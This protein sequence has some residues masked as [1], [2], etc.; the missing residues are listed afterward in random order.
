MGTHTPR[1]APVI[2][3]LLLVYGGAS[4]VHFTH[5]AEYLADYPN[6]PTWL[7]PSVIYGAWIATTALGICG[8]LLLRWGY[9]ALGFCV[10]A[11]YAAIGFDSLTHYMVAPFEHHTVT[12]HVTIWL[13]VGAAGTLLA[14]L[15][16]VM[17]KLMWSKTSGRAY[18]A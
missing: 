15:A 7:S 3:A 6:M 18:D 16:C 2:V 13:E 12:M 10:I 8:Y 14:T 5:N 4:L 11:A 17:A 1:V 9:R